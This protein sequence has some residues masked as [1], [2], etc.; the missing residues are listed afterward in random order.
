[1]RASLPQLAAL[2]LSIAVACSV[3]LA[4]YLVVPGFER[5]FAH[6]ELEL[7]PRTQVLFATYRWWPGH[8][9]AV[10]LAW[11]LS[12]SPARGARSATIVGLLGALALAGFG[13]WAL[14]E[15][16]IMLQLIEQSARPQGAP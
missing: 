15:P 7:A 10:A 8:V 1:M 4:A 11:V 3:S 6:Y 2:V 13:W 14:Q 9:L 16:Q 5:M 12:S